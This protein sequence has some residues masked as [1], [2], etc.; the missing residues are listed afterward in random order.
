MTNYQH[1]DIHPVAGS[2]GAEIRGI[3]ISQPLEPG[4]L[5][6]L[7][8]AWLEYLVLFFREQELESEQFKSFARFAL[9]ACNKTRV[10]MPL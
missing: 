1:I 4:V 8:R 5:Q 3:D 9:A 7:N 10:S 6:E 2:L